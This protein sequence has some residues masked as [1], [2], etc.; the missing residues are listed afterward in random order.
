MNRRAMFKAL[1]FAPA[2]LIVAPTVANA[3]DTT[4]MQAVASAITNA[5]YDAQITK[6]ADSSWRVTARSAAFDIPIASA[7]SLA[8]S[9]GVNGFVREAL[10]Y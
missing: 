4:K 7:N 8:V 6:Q 2:A 3:M 9:Q 10:F 5:G 1:L